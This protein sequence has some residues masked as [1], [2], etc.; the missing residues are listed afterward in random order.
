MAEHGIVGPALAVVMDGTGY[1]EDGTVWGGEFLEVEVNEYRR[2]GHLK[3]IPLPGGDRAIKEPWR[4]G[5]AYLTR[6]FGNLEYIR[7]PFTERLNHENWSQLRGAMEA[8]IN[9]PPCS[10]AGRLFD[11]VSAIIGVRDLVNYEGQAAVELEQIAGEGE[12][13]AYTFKVDD[14]KG[15]YIVDPDPIISAIVEELKDG[16]PPSRISSRFHN[17]LARAIGEVAQR[18]REHTG[19]TE[20]ILSGGVFQNALLSE[21]AETLLEN[22][23][24]VVYTHHLVPPNDGGISLGQA[25]YG[26]S[27]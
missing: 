4:M 5:A 26:A 23:G 25:F 19:L 18:M 27:R 17:T 10:S 11:A 20:I 16:L 1:G 3:Y 22:L 14:S 13:G 7:I 8:K 2:W 12:Q 6:I 21:R 15:T 9:C 24:F